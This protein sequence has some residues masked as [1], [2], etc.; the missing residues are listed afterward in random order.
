MKQ[1]SQGKL[2]KDVTDQDSLV[3]YCTIHQSDGW[4]SSKILHCWLAAIL[5]ILS[6]LL[7]LLSVTSLYVIRD[8]SIE[9]RRHLNWDATKILSL[10]CISEKSLN[11]KDV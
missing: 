4:S 10:L 8:E 11:I 5:F 2:S 7:W 3:S 6:L 1:E 9:F